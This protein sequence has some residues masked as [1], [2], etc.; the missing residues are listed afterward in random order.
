MA[1]AAAAVTILSD[2]STWDPWFEQTR[3]SVPSHMWRYFDLDT[4]D[5]FTAPLPPVRLVDYPLPEGI[6]TIRQLE[7]RREENRARLDLYIR[8]FPLY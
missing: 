5:T 8:E 7:T 1:A 2:P 3:A 6:E 4:N